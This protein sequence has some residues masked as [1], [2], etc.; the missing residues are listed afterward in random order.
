VIFICQDRDHAIQFLDAAD[1]ELTGDVSRP[2]SDDD[3][4]VGQRRIAVCLERSV[5]EGSP[6]ACSFHRAPA[7]SGTTASASGA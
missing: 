2:W 1:R 5:Y 3:D 7:A 4:Y 6:H